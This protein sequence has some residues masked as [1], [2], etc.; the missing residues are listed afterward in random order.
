M[1]YKFIDGEYEVT[2]DYFL[3]H[4]KFL[5]QVEREDGEDVVNGLA[6]YICS[7]SDMEQIKNEL[8]EKLSIE[9]PAEIEK[10]LGYTKNFYTQPEPNRGINYKSFFEDVE[11]AVEATRCFCSHNEWCEDC[12]SSSFKNQIRE[13]IR[14]AH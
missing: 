10:E 9:V 1:S 5:F 8:K 3:I 11:K 6:T 14:K 2:A 4:R 12:S 7:N 13:L